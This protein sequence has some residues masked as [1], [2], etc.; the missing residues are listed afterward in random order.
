M[1]FIMNPINVKIGA[2]GDPPLFPELG[3]KMVFEGEITH[4]GILQE[5]TTRGECSLGFNIQLPDGRYVF[6]QM[7]AGMLIMIAAAGA[8][9]VSSD[10]Y[11]PGNLNKHDL[12]LYEVSGSAW[13][14]WLGCCGEWMRVI[15]A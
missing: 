7:T 13:A 8:E 2:V 3:P 12:L 11:I 15:L 1:E 6:A 4:V 10:D 5:G 14:P 9:I